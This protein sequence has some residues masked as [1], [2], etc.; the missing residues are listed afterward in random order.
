MGNRVLYRNNCP[1]CAFCFHLF[2]DH[3]STKVCKP[4]ASRTVFDYTVTW[5]WEWK[6]AAESQVGRGYR[7]VVWGFLVVGFVWGF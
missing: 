3:R 4:L 5:C 6:D 1:L 2:S 7:D